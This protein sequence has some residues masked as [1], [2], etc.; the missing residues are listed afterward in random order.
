M[1]TLITPT[2]D[3]PEAFR[4][5]EWLI[6][7]QTVPWY[8]WIIA[9]GGSQKLTPTMGQEHLIVSHHE[10]PVQNF[11]ANLRAALDR[12]QD[13]ELIAFIEDDDWYAPEYLQWIGNKLQ[14]HDLVGAARAKYY[15]LTN[16]LWKEMGNTHHASFCQTGVTRSAVKW[17]RN[18]LRSDAGN[19]F[20]DMH[21]WK[22]TTLN[23]PSRWLEPES[24]LTIGMKGLP[25]KTGLGNGHRINSGR[26]DSS[27]RMLK[28]L[29]DL[30]SFDKYMEM[31]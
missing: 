17:L 9:D 30:E 8:R 16:A 24:T 4:M 27:R 29:V 19:A 18:Y 13:N 31:L 7:R 26:D 14:S 5:C 25:G 15:H 6:K 2:S 12:V 20:V 21:L 3:R 23:I 11:R 10:N 1:L 22:D 28:Q